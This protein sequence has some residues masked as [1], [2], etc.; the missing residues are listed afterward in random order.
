MEQATDD[1][2]TK[3]PPLRWASGSIKI[4]ATTLGETGGDAVSMSMGLG[5]LVGT[6][7]FAVIVLVSVAAQIK[8]RRFHSAIYWTTLA[9]AVASR[10]HQLGFHRRDVDIA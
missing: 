7:I 5:Y 10:N 4:A 1:R 9:G 8:A 3:F 2:P 6:A